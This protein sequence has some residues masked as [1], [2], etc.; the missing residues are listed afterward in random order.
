MKVKYV[1]I[2]MWCGHVEDWNLRL[3]FETA[4]WK[5]RDFYH[6]SYQYYSKYNEFDTENIQ[7]SVQLELFSYQ[8]Q[9]GKHA[10]LSRLVSNDKRQWRSIRN[11]RRDK[12]FLDG[13]RCTVSVLYCFVPRTC[14]RHV[15]NSTRPHA[16]SLGNALPCEHKTSLT[17]R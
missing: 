14:L 10:G 5:W 12:R 7:I 6:I 9:Q 8:T 2:W 16:E 3:C 11:P 4:R 17:V 13:S 15:E 1:L